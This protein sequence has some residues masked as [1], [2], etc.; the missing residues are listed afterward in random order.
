MRFL[1]QSNLICFSKYGNDAKLHQEREK[2]DKKQ[3]DL[4]LTSLFKDYKTILEKYG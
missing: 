2:L 4:N 3:R 1:E